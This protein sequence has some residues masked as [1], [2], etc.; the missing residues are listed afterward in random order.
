MVDLV[1]RLAELEVETLRSEL[2]ATIRAERATGH[3]NRAGAAPEPDTTCPAIHN[4]PVTTEDFE[5]PKNRAEVRTISHVVK[6]LSDSNPGQALGLH[7][8]HKLP[9][10]GASQNWNGERDKLKL[11]RSRPTANQPKH[12]AHST[13]PTTTKI[14]PMDT[15]S[16]TH[17]DVDPNPAPM[18]DHG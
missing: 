14:E 12:T 10:Q 16:D 2:R 3:H 5:T 11:D 1:H 15:D 7:R 13:S 9:K 18:G 6:T 17:S 4:R 8:M